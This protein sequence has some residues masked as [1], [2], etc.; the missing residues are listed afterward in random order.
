MSN[1]MR[2]WWHSRLRGLIG[3]SVKV[4]LPGELPWVKVIKEFDG[5]IKGRIL[6][7][8]YSEYSEHEHAQFMKR[9]CGG[10]EE[11]P[12]LHDFKK[13]DELWFEKGTG[14]REGHWVPVE[15]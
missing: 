5:R 4:L 3:E 12:K 15:K 1:R 9:E 8:L 13:G 14:N 10:V 11:L 2:S 7:K 6:N